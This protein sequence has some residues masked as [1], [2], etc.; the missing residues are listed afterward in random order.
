[1]RQPQIP[2]CGDVVQAFFR[3]LCVLR[4]VT[5]SRFTCNP[6]VRPPLAVFVPQWGAANKIDY[7]SVSFCRSAADLATVRQLLD[8]WAWCG[9][10]AFPGVQLS[11][12][13]GPAAG[14]QGGGT[15]PPCIQLLDG[16][17]CLS[18]CV[19]RCWERGGGKFAP[20]RRLLASQGIERSVRKGNGCWD[21][22]TGRQAAWVGVGG[23]PLTCGCVPTLCS[24]SCGLQ[25]TKLMA[26]IENMEGLVNSAEIIEACD[27]LLFSRGNLGI[28][29]EAEKASRG[30]CANGRREGTHR[31]LQVA[32]ALA[33][34]T[35]AVRVFGCRQTAS[36]GAPLSLTPCQPPPLR[37]HASVSC[38]PSLPFSACLP[39]PL[40]SSPRRCSWPRSRCCAPPTWRASPSS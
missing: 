11:V 34:C 22:T 8:R 6:S 23:G 21:C 12:A 27:A 19:C 35:G 2:T 38:L 40:R 30:G 33:L 5:P 13:L 24:R 26:K 31:V 17:G 39:S 29:L 18:V 14:L 4:P 36:R 37:Q 3:M 10:G 20:A 32:S 1:M 25:Q 7:V 15:L 9:V 28:C 16:R